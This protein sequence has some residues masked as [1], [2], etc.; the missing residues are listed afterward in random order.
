MSA[1]WEIG[2]AGAAGA[3]KFASPRNK[4][5]PLPP[6][7]SNLERVVLERGAAA[8]GL[9]T[10]PAPFLINTVPYNGR[11][12]CGRCGM[13][14][15]FACPT[16]GKNGTQNTMIPRA[17]ATGHCT[18]M[19]GAIVQRIQTDQRGRA[20]GVSFFVND[21]LQT[22][23]AG[24]VVCSAGAIES[25]RLLLN[26]ATSHQPRGLGNDFDQVG[27]HLQGH[28][29]SGAF[30]VMPES[31]F[32][33]RGPGVSIATTQFNHH[34][35]GIIGGGLLANE[36]I[37]LPALFVK[38]AMPPGQPRWG[39]AAKQYVREN[40]QRTIQVQGPIQEIPNPDA[41]VTIDPS[42]RD[43][44][45]IPVVRLSGTV[46]PESVR[47]ADFLRHRA[48]EWLAASGAKRVW[49]WPPR[50]ALSGGQHQAGTCRMGIDP[51]MSVTDQ[52]G[53]VHGHD[54]LFVMDG[55]VHVTN[56][57]FNPV[58]TIMALA[59]RNAMHLAEL[60]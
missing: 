60:S 23:T 11:P 21:R 35:Q 15:G 8:L 29:Y 45:G 14:V 44:W 28:M 59:Y 1:E 34:N 16:D 30:G 27:R 7:E 38:W 12:A 19:T 55:S 13:C 56:G 2:V 18:L 36:F 33:G 47:A 39:L 50:V 41:R 3:D 20:S 49:S 22:V 58:L 24:V 25:A 54:N 6:V 43:R 10:F 32:D 42:V 46:H 9:N 53:R 5:Y 31:V 40:Y 57:G 48:E 51:R 17:L 26:S 4:A 37:K 52:W